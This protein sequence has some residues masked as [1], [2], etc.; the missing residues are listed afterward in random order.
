MFL[1]ISGGHIGAPKLYTTMAAPGYK[2]A[3]NVS[4]NYSET[5]VGHKD[6]RLGQIV[7]ILVFYNTTFSW[8]LPQDGFQCIFLLRD[9]EN[10]LLINHD[11]KSSCRLIQD[12]LF[13]NWKFGFDSDPRLHDLKRIVHMFHYVESIYFLF[14][15]TFQFSFK[16]LN[17]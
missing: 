5:A 6:L 12:S 17:G 8:L 10:D 13:T 1:L 4:A 7:Y 3:W 14:N 16:Q 9:S 15:K 11:C 2:G